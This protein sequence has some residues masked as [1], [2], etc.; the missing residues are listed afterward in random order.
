MAL[1]TSE[2][3]MAGSSVS[4]DPQ[5]KRG[6]GTKDL[7][8]VGKVCGFGAMSSG[9]GGV[10]AVSVGTRAGD[11]VSCLAGQDD[12]DVRI[13]RRAGD[14]NNRAVLGLTVCVPTKTCASTESSRS[15]WRGFASFAGSSCACETCVKVK[16]RVEACS[17]VTAER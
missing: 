7:R 2:R 10:V 6:M 11:G 1:S 12:G 14:G 8:G 16:P 3:I 5:S 13:R 4:I 15:K 17:L 9:A